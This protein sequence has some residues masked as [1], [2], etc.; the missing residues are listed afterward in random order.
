MSFTQ[1]V[2]EELGVPNVGFWTSSGCSLW[3]FTQYP[4][5]VEQGY[6]PL[7]DESYLDTIIDWIPGMEGIRLKHL[8]S[9]IRATVD[10][11]SYIIIKYI[12]EEILDKIPKFS[13][14]ILNT[15]D[16]LESDVLQQ[17]ATKFPVVNYTIGPLHRFLLNNPTQVEDLKSIGSNLWK[18]ET[19]C[20]E[21]L[22]TKKPNSVVYVNF[23]SVTVM[24][25]EQLIEFAWGLANA[26]MDFL[27][28]VRSNLVMGDSAILPHEFLAETKERCL[29]GGWCPQEQVLSHPSIGGFLTH[30][31]WNSTFES[32]S[33]GV[34]MLCWPFFADQQTNSWFN[35]N[36]WGV[37]MEIDSNVKRE[38][39]EELVRELMVG[40]KGKEM[41]ENALNWKKLAEKA[42]NSSDGSSCMN[43]D[44]LV[45]H[46]LLGKGL[47]P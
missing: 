32:L 18:E 2:S 22:D 34:P 19:H 15:F 16:M 40:E 44:K 42:I 43:F 28:I 1:Q 3:A 33:Y 8:P 21:W 37:G 26:K 35:C 10:E 25:N 9:F 38:V 27:W 31:G 4:K 30:C 36:R 5:L 7:K 17:M 24:S 41:K 47:S 29:L 6:A 14:L 11:P 23:G 46:V 45:S 12:V 20:L 39:I 13:A